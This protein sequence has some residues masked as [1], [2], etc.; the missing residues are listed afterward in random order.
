MLAF[1]PHVKVH[2]GGSAGIP[3]VQK[4]QVTRPGSCS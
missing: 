1:H 2:E 3:C 4:G